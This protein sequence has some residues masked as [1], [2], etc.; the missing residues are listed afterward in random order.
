M[1]FNIASMEQVDSLISS[2]ENISKIYFKKFEILYN[3]NSNTCSRNDIPEIVFELY[4]GDIF[5][6]KVPCHSERFIEAYNKL[7]SFIED[8]I[9]FSI[10]EFTEGYFKYIEI[11]DIELHLKLYSVNLHTLIRKVVPGLIAADLVGVQ[12]M[13]E[14]VG[15]IF[16]IRVVKDY[17]TDFDGDI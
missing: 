6:F 4:T 17:I 14:Q 5:N 8:T 3:K 11:A 12:P 16:P 15:Q 13:S 7:I 1:K 9:G 10:E 2:K